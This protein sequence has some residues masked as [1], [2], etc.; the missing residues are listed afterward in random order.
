VLLPMSLTAVLVS[1]T[2]GRKR[3]I[4]WK[5]LAGATSQVIACLLILALHAGSAIWL[6]VVIAMVVGIPQGLINLAN[7][8]AVYYQA[9]PARIGASAGLLRTFFYMG[10]IASSAAT[11]GF[12]GRQAD[13][14]GLHGLAIFLLAAAGLLLALVVVDRSLAKAGKER[15]EA[16]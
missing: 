7:Q 15:G 1:S 12:F 13:T 5:L 8:N 11:G 9:E 6:L 16:A 2:T 14:T 10:A 4:R 3:E